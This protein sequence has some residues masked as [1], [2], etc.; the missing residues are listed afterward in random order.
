MSIIISSNLVGPWGGLTL[1][2]NWVT[3]FNQTW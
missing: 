1:E 3:N 2:R